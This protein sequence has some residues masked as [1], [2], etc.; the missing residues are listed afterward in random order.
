[1]FACPMLLPFGCR[2]A[3]LV[4]IVPPIGKPLSLRIYTP[5]PLVNFEPSTDVAH[6]VIIRLLVS[7]APNP[8]PDR[9]CVRSVLPA[10]V[11]VPAKIA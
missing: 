8:C 3:G 9:I 7:E 6:C 11:G 2:F 5:P 10:P 1:M 4:A